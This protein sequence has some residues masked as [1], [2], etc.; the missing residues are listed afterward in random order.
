MGDDHGRLVRLD[1]ARQ[2]SRRAYTD[3]PVV[4]AADFGFA[5]RTQTL[6]QKVRVFRRC[7]GGA[8]LLTHAFAGRAGTYVGPGPHDRHP[9]RCGRDVACEPHEDGRNKKARGASSCSCPFVPS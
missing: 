1:H 6:P 3:L 7:G 5:A 2:V 8:R 4:S 9:H